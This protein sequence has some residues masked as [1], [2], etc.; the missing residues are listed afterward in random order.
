MSTAAME[1][2]E[3]DGPH[4]LMGHEVCESAIAAIAD[5]AFFEQVRIVEDEGRPRQQPQPVLSLRPRT[6][7]SMLR[8]QRARRLFVP[9]HCMGRAGRCL[10]THDSGDWEGWSP[11]FRPTP[12]WHSG[13]GLEGG[14]KYLRVGKIW[15]LGNSIFSH[16]CWVVACGSG[17]Q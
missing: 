12:D 9:Y 16:C 10:F 2:T 17:A 1:V 8:G 6:G 7:G 3:L 15:G 13:C 11:P 14:V 4:S 5:H